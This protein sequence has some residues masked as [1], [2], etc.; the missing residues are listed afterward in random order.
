MTNNTTPNYIF[1][2][3]KEV[4]E[5]KS[6]LCVGKLR[7]NFVGTEFSL[8]D[9]GDNPKVGDPTKTRKELAFV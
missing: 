6:D 9:S 1:S 5:R 4:F 8:F 3:S 7:S 2:L